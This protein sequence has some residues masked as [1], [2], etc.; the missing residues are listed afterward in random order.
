MATPLPCSPPIRHGSYRRWTGPR[1]GDTGRKSA[2]PVAQEASALSS[3]T[4]ESSTSTMSAPNPTRDCRA[5]RHDNPLTLRTS[6]RLACEA[7]APTYPAPRGQQWAR[8]YVLPSAGFSTTG[9]S[10]GRM[11][12]VHRTPRRVPVATEDRPRSGRGSAVA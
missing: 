9:S 1:N 11:G 8:R 7:G 3:S 12:G 10:V 2:W 4:S 5:L 6:T